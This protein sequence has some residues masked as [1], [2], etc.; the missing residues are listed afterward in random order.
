MAEFFGRGLVKTSVILECREN[1]HHTGIIDWLA[2]DFMDNG[3]NIKRGKTNCNVRH[4][5]NR[6]L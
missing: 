4:I 1:R 5:V 3:W 6:L 2:L